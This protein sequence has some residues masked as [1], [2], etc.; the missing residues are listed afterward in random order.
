MGNNIKTLFEFISTMSSLYVPPYHREYNWSCD[1]CNTLLEKT[2]SENSGDIDFG[3][4]TYQ[5]CDEKENYILVDGYQRLVT[6]LLFIQA[7][8]KSSKI[9]LAPKNHPSNFLISQI[10]DKE[11]FKLKINNNDKCDIQLILKNKFSDS[12]FNNSNFLNNY[13][14]FFENITEKKIPLIR[15]IAN[16]S[17]IKIINI[18]LDDNKKNEDQMY[19][20]LNGTFSPKN[21]ISNYVYKQLKDEKQIHIYN[22]YWLGLESL[23]KEKSESFLTDYLTIQNNGLIPQKDELY[24]NFMNFFQKISKLKSK[25]DMIKHLFRYANYYIKITTSDIKDVEIKKRLDIINDYK[26]SDTYPYLMEVFEDYEFAHI[27]KHM[28]IEILETITSFVEQREQS[29]PNKFGLNF[30]QLSSDINRMLALKDYTPKIVT[31]E[32]DENFLPETISERLTI[33]DIIKNKA[34]I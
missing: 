5:K 34:P 15:L 12:S 7:L 11:I 29:N 25:E 13:E 20:D 6:I 22:T 3:I 2:F 17:K 33:N 23:L 30:A 32:I 19:F 4:I 21:H 28:L 26:A 8:I 24:L 1:D 31:Q 18:I 27:N 9:N 16:I 14:F 10:E